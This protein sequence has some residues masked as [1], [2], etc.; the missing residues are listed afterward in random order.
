LTKLQRF[1]QQE[2]IL[3]EKMINGRRKGNEWK[4]TQMVN[5]E[6]IRGQGMLNEGNKKVKEFAEKAL[7]RYI[8][9]RLQDVCIHN[10]GNFFCSLV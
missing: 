3:I 4:T 10:V 8:L 2:Q 5:E 6:Q 9:L 1:I 7:S